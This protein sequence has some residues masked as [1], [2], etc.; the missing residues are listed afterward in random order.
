[1]GTKFYTNLGRFDFSGV[2]MGGGHAVAI[3][4][5][6]GVPIPPRQTKRVVEIDLVKVTQLQAWGVELRA[7]F[8]VAREMA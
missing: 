8:A 4:E 1:M 3:V 5:P 6:D 7:K 2:A